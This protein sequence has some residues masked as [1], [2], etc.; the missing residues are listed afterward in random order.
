MI[1]QQSKLLLSLYQ[2]YS[3]GVLLKSGGVFDQPNF[4]MQAME[5]L[6]QEMSKKNA[7][8]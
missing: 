8:N 2:H 5:I 3:N 6:D 7:D 4:Y 1:T